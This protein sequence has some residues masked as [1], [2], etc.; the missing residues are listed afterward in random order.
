V[1]SGTGNS[2]LGGI[3][4]NAEIKSLQDQMANLEKTFSNFQPMTGN[5]SSLDSRFAKLDE[6]MASIEKKL[7]KIDILEI[8]A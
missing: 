8:Q 7:E 4:G 5:G 1:S 6:W 3:T 2:T